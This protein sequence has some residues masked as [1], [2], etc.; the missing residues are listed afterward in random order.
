M[1]DLSKG[2]DTRWNRS[3]NDGHRQLK[4]DAI[5]QVFEQRLKDSDQIDT[6]DTI[7][8]AV[9][10]DVGPCSQA[11]R[12]HRDA[13]HFVLTQT[14]NIRLSATNSSVHSTSHSD[15]TARR[16][17]RGRVIVTMAESPLFII[18]VEILEKIFQSLFSVPDSEIWLD[19][20]PNIR[21]R[22][23]YQPP[24]S[25]LRTCKQMAETG[26]RALRSNMQDCQLILQLYDFAS[27]TPRI[28]SFLEQYGELF[29]DLEVYSF[30]RCPDTEPLAYLIN[31]KQITLC[32]GVLSLRHHR[33]LYARLDAMDDLELDASWGWL[34]LSRH[35]DL[36]AWILKA[37]T[38]YL[39]GHDLSIQIRTDAHWLQDQGYTLVR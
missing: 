35:P 24:L 28:R 17:H 26:K 33:P 12:Y 21:A 13:I 8:G 19:Y 18:P 14:S 25:I 30:P 34:W 27:R 4:S 5:G 15:L 36:S 31:I 32:C 38:C 2:I 10:G 37:K 6:K 7:W 16:I 3:G 9:V 29:E 11:S 20:D 1:N 39:P 23:D 22:I